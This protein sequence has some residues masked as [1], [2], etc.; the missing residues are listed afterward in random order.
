[1]LQMWQIPRERVHVV[2]RDNVANM[3]KAMHEGGLPTLPCMAHTLQLAVH[4]R[5]LAQRMTTDILAMGRRIIG[6]LK[7]LSQA[8][9][10]FQDVQQQLGQNIKKFQQDMTTQWNSSYY[11]FQSLLEQ[12]FAL[13]AFGAEHEIPASFSSN[14]WGLIENIIKILKP[15]E[16]LTRGLSSS[17]ASAADVIPSVMALKWCL[18][19]DAPSDQGVGTTKAKLLRAVTRW[20]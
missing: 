9:C 2:I 17:T 10:A 7:H 3:A 19:R 12:K 16:E 4:D 15:F 1:M 11:M 6:H 13:A 14:Q 20:D 8:Y 18:S 5:L